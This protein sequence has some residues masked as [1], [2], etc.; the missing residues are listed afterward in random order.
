MVPSSA[1]MHHASTSDVPILGPVR[2]LNAR[3]TFVIYAQIQNA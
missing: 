3:R 1:V 2:H